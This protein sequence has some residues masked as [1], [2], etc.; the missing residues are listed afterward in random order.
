MPFR[1]RLFNFAQGKAPHL[2][3]LDE[4]KGIHGLARIDS[5]IVV[6]SPTHRAIQQTG[7]LV[8]ANGIARNVAG[9]P[10]LQSALRLLPRKIRLTLERTPWSTLCTNQRRGLDDGCN[11][12]DY[13]RWQQW[14]RLSLR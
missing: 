3:L 11:D 10:V 12:H 5:I 7:F 9:W 1:E 13:H 2:P 4:G 8:V 6:G 14:A